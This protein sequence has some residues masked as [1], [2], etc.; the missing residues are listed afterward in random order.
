MTAPQTNDWNDNNMSI[1]KKLYDQAKEAQKELKIRAGDAL[2]S[3]SNWEGIVDDYYAIVEA[4]AMTGEEK[5]FFDMS[6]YS[7]ATI[8]RVSI[9]LKEKLEDVLIVVC[10]RGIEANWEMCE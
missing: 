4:Q 10:P 1:K 2:N 5:H 7:Q 3:V 6:D 9:A 8:T